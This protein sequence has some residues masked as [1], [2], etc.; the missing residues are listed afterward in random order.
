MTP[1][2]DAFATELR[3]SPP[4]VT[5][6]PGRHWLMGCRA[7]CRKNGTKRQ[8][9][10]LALPELFLFRIVDI[11]PIYVMLTLKLLADVPCMPVTWLTEKIGVGMVPLQGVLQEPRFTTEW[12]QSNY[13]YYD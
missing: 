4:Q 6:L 1:A 3:V 5:V 9:V 8:H 2:R 7:A 10:L 11:N 12:R 13:D